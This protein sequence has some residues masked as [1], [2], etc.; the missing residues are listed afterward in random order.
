MGARLRG[1]TATQRSKKGSEKVLGKG[2]EKGGCCGFYSKKRV[3]RRVLRRGSEKGVSRRC[4]ERPLEEYVPLGVRPTKARI[5][6]AVP[7]GFR[8]DSESRPIGFPNRS[9]NR[10]RRHP[11]A[12]YLRPSRRATAQGPQWIVVSMPKLGLGRVQPAYEGQQRQPAHCTSTSN[13]CSTLAL[14]FPRVL[15]WMYQDAFP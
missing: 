7:I 8:N 9:S 12:R 6:L 14:G 3:L 1:R 2:S 11:E 15:W 10:T 13:T 4:L 5:L